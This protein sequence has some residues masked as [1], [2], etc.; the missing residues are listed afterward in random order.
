MAF[1]CVPHSILLS[2]LSSPITDA[3]DR[4]VPHFLIAAEHCRGINR[5]LANS[6]PKG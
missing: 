3:M 2:Y 1:D 6:S 4:C 5:I